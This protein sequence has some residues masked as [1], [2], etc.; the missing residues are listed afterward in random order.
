MGGGIYVLGFF[1]MKRGSIRNN[2][3]LPDANGYSYGGGVYIRSQDAVS[4]EGGDISGNTASGGKG[5]GG[6]I[7]V[8]EGSVTMSG[9]SVSGNTAT[10][11]GGG[12]IVAKNAVFNQRGG[13]VSGNR[14]P[15]Y[16]DIYRD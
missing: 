2:T 4:I 6:G 7:W 5:G 1:T 13:T 11:V 8:S 16:A 15:N 9:G 3:A 12:V 14:A 10:V